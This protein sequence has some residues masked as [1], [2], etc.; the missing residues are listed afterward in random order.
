MCPYA[1]CLVAEVDK[2]FWLR[3]ALLP[4]VISR[5]RGGGRGGR[6]PGLRMTNRSKSF[7]YSRRRALSNEAL[8][9]EAT[10]GEE[11]RRRRKNRSPAGGVRNTT[12]AK[13]RPEF[14]HLKDGEA[15]DP[16]RSSRRASPWGTGCAIVARKGGARAAHLSSNEGAPDREKLHRLTTKGRNRSRRV[17]PNRPYVHREKARAGIE[18]DR[19]RGVRGSV[20]VVRGFG[21]TRPHSAKVTRRSDRERRETLRS[22]AKVGGIPLFTRPTALAR[23]SRR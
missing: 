8:H 2:R 22:L 12:Q 17:S 19:D 23:G 11:S 4:N 13:S 18:E 5:K 20:T 6:G 16:W 3:E 14:P 15:R 7:R 1:V 9:C 10:R 21:R